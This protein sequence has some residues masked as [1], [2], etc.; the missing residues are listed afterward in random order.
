MRCYEKVIAAI[1]AVAVLVGLEP[2]IEVLRH[3]CR[4][5]SVRQRF[6]RNDQRLYRQSVRQHRQST[7]GNTR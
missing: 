1:M 6:R 4:R 3:L 2:N 7:H 5:T